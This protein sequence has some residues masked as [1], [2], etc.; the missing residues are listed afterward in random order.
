MALI[1]LFLFFYLS[2]PLFPWCWYFL[3]SFCFT[4]LQ[5][6]ENGHH[7]DEGN[8]SNVCYIFDCYTYDHTYLVSVMWAI[9]KSYYCRNYRCPLQWRRLAQNLMASCEDPIL[10]ANMYVFATIG[11]CIFKL[12]FFF[13]SVSYCFLPFFQQEN[14]DAL[15]NCVTKD[16]GFSHGKAVAAFTIYKC[17]IH[18]KSCEAERTNVFDRLIQ[19]IGYAIEVIDCI[20]HSC[21]LWSNGGRQCHLLHFPLLF[22]L[23]HDFYFL[24]ILILT[25]FH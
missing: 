8:K 10:N 9:D 23:L 13:C 7:M 17:L 18:W 19:M 21:C 12:F 24:L 16:I 14:V 25:N 6:L 20:I 4:N 22:Y 1:F 3:L 11:F 2:L 15:I 5:N